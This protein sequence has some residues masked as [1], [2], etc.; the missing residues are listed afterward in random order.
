ML[1]LSL[2][3]ACESAL[4]NQRTGNLSFIEVIET[5]NM[6]RPL[7]GGDGEPSWAPLFVPM[8][9]VSIFDWSDMDIADRNAPLQVRFRVR[10]PDGNTHI[11]PNDAPFDSEPPIAPATRSRVEWVFV[12]FPLTVPGDYYIEVAHDDT[13]LGEYKVL[14]LGF[15]LQASEQPYSGAAVQQE[16]ATAK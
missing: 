3:V 7:F 4:I 2:L 15:D 12:G 10:T 6:P 16:Q 14:V 9:V 5:I 13:V 8:K 11:Q 1:K